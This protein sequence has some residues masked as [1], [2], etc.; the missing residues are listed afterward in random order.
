M[1]TLVVDRRRGRFV[2]AAELFRAFPLPTDD[3]N[4]SREEQHCA[5]QA[6]LLLWSHD[7]V[8]DNE[9]VRHGGRP[10]GGGRGRGQGRGGLRGGRLYTPAHFAISLRPR[11][12]L[13]PVIDLDASAGSHLGVAV[14]REDPDSLQCEP[15]AKR[16]RRAEPLQ[17]VPVADT[18]SASSAQ[19][20]ESPLTKRMRCTEPLRVMPVAAAISAASVQSA[21]SGTAPAS[22]TM[23]CDS[24]GHT[25]P[26][27]ALADALPWKANQ[28]LKVKYDGG[29]RPGLERE[30]VYLKAEMLSKGLAVVVKEVDT[31][32]RKK[33]QDKSYYYV[34]L[35]RDVIDVRTGHPAPPPALTGSAASGSSLPSP[36]AAPSVVPHSTPRQLQYCE[37]PRL[38]MAEDTCRLSVRGAVVAADSMLDEAAYRDPA[39]LFSGYPDPKV[40]VRLDSNAP[41]GVMPEF[42]DVVGEKSLTHWSN[43]ADRGWK[44]SHVPDGGGAVSFRKF[45]ARSLNSWRLAYLL[46][47][48]QLQLWSPVL[49]GDD[50][51]PPRPSSFAD[52]SGA[53]NSA[54]GGV[55][56]IGVKG[57]HE[58]HEE[59]GD[60]L[61][62][63]LRDAKPTD[64][65]LVRWYGCHAE[66]AGGRAYVQ[67]GDGC[68]WR[69]RLHQRARLIYVEIEDGAGVAKGHFD[70]VLAGGYT[71]TLPRNGRCFWHGLCASQDP[72]EYRTERS[73]GGAAVDAEKAQAEITKARAIMMPYLQLLKE[74]GRGHHVEGFLSGAILVEDY[75]I[76]EIS[77]T[78]AVDIELCIPGMHAARVIPRPIPDHGP[79]IYLIATESANDQERLKSVNFAFHRVL[80]PTEVANSDVYLKMRQGRRKEAAQM[81]A[82][83]CFLGHLAVWRGVGDRPCI[84]VESDARLIRPVPS[85]L[86][87]DQVGCPLLLGGAMR[88]AGAWSKEQQ[89]HYESGAYLKAYDQ[90]ECNTWFG[91]PGKW[92]MSVAYYLPQK[93][94]GS[95]SREVVCPHYL[96]L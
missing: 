59:D 14:K 75:M 53:C 71:I 54:G 28:R 50:G 66:L 78:L 82:I 81:Q 85:I 74:T 61:D 23:H 24:A 77:S 43:A 5:R 52:G 93:W 73:A 72:S 34:H 51:A 94:F 38:D 8:V 65:E 48:L 96:L 4:V 70:A 13:V 47:R 7:F 80:S 33:G 19:P 17:T 88:T 87:S 56:S 69:R 37:D 40:H 16:R 11:S 68:M 25:G 84:V 1:P 21:G 45:S 91:L 26:Q 58:E 22:A 60:D 29:S 46:A 2:L 31:S 55:A 18:T 95:Y 27:S 86:S 30:V 10:R 3:Y 57:E 12:P 67:D 32:H 35:M 76:P 83:S 64:D 44:V 89:E 62:D 9:P 42:G 20:A 41:P 6:S 79:Q 49:D 39:Q 92:T 15:P 36:P 90:M 63:E